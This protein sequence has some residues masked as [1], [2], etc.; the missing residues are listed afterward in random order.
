MK[1][2]FEYVMRFLTGGKGYYKYLFEIPFTIRALFCRMDGH[3]C[4][5]VWYNPNGYE[6]DMTCKNCGDD[7]G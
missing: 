4:G 7:L 1:R 2:Y 5:V 3:K 6:P